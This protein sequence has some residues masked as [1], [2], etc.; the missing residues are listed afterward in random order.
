MQHYWLRRVA[1]SPDRQLVR[2]RAKDA[3]FGLQC[4]LLP[5]PRIDQ[6]QVLGHEEISQ[7]IHFS[8]DLG[9]STL[10]IPEDV[11]EPLQVDIRLV[12]KPFECVVQGSPIYKAEHSCRVNETGLRQLC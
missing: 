7:C 6:L 8:T 12:A 1:A 3:D 9:A 4:V 2:H 11:G 10:G 5:R